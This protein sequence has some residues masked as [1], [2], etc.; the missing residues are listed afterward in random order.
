MSDPRVRVVL[1]CDWFLS[2]T[3][4]QAAALAA[5][6]AHLLLLIRVH[7]NQYATDNAERDSPIAT[8]TRRPSRRP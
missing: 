3:G 1:T 4:E 6:A 2:Y 7:E 5:L 8:A